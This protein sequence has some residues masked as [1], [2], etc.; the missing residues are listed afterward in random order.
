M[1]RRSK[2]HRRTL[3]PRMRKCRALEEIH[4]IMERT[5]EEEKGLTAVT[6]FRSGSKS[7]QVLTCA[8]PLYC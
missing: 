3:R 8:D 1:A 2:P 4:E 6:I 5:H 7:E